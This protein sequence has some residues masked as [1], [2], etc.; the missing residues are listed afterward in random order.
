[1]RFWPSKGVQKRDR[2]RH[3]LIWFGLPLSTVVCKLCSRI[4][5]DDVVQ[6]RTEESLVV[7]VFPIPRLRKESY[8]TGRCF[9][10]EGM[11]GFVGLPVI[12]CGCKYNQ[13]EKK[14]RGE[15]CEIS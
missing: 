3:I 5:L 8:I 1:M 7:E 15:N 12:T 2:S 6:D 13:R 4:C 9:A 11:L 10:I 14:S